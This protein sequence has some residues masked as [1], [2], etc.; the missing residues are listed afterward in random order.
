MDDLYQQVLRH[1]EEM[2]ENPH[3]LFPQE[4]LTVRLALYFMRGLLASGVA[5][6]DLLFGKVNKEAA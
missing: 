4:R 1:M 2:T 5:P 3:A 6:A